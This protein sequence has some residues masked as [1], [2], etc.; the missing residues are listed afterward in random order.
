MCCSS[1][2]VEKHRLHSLFYSSDAISLSPITE[3]S[4]GFDSRLPSV[5]L[6]RLS[7]GVCVIIKTNRLPCETWLALSLA[8][9][10]PIDTVSLVWD[11]GL[12]CHCCQTHPKCLNEIGAEGWGGSG[13]K[14][15]DDLSCL[16]LHRQAERERQYELPQAH[17]PP[18]PQKEPYLIEQVFSPYPYTPTVKTHVKG[19]PLYTDL[20]LSSVSEGK[21]S[22]PSWTIDEYK[23][24][25]GE[26]GKQLTALDLQ[27][28]EW[29]QQQHQ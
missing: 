2:K 22:Q 20:R 5:P 21:R 3:C 11:S 25:S 9:E 7:Q 26:K 17:R 19:S 23:R 24:N 6:C 4:V 16:P 28:L 13:G 10:A 1:R 18:K 15:P 27:V 14:V 12:V 29:Q 8:G